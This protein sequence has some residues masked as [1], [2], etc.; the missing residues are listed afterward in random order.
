MEV[1][2]L[3]VLLQYMKRDINKL[4]LLLLLLITGKYEIICTLPTVVP[5]KYIL[6]CHEYEYQLHC[7]FTD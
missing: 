1:C 2:R 3:E 5:H 4:I 6:T 7:P